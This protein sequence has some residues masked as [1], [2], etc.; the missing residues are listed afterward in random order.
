VTVLRFNTPSPLQQVDEWY[1]NH[2]GKTF[3][4]NQG[5]VPGRDQEDWVIDVQDSPNPQALV[6]NRRGAGRVQGVII[7]TDHSVGTVVTLYE[8]WQLGR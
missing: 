6:Y 3:S 8:F 4:R 2:L 1:Q 7:E 5:W